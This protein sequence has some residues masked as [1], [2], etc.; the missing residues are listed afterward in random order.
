MIVLSNVFQIQFLSFAF[1]K[2]RY[3]IEIE[4]KTETQVE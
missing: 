4:N 1:Y 2:G 3:S